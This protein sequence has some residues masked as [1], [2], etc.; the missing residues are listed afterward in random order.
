MTPINVEWTFFQ[1]KSEV[2][3]PV[4]EILSDYVVIDLETTGLK[5][6]KDGII[7]I[8]AVRYQDGKAIGAYHTSEVQ[9]ARRPGASCCPKHP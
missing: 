1:G 7:E 8:A 4:G 3:K 6:Y 5:Y 9:A 2:C